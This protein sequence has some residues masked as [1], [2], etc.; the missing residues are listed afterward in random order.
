VF[1]PPVDGSQMGRKALAAQCQQE[2]SQVI[3]QVRQRPRAVKVHKSQPFNPIRLR[4][5]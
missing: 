3:E 2:V 5:K 1:L 4:Q